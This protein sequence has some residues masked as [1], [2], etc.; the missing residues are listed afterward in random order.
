MHIKRFKK[1]FTKPADRV[2][3]WIFERRKKCLFIL[4]LPLTLAFHL[5]GLWIVFHHLDWIGVATFKDGMWRWGTLLTISLF[6]WFAVAYSDPIPITHNVWNAP[7]D[8]F[9]NVEDRVTVV[10]AM[11]FLLLIHVLFF[12]G[13]SWVVWCAHN[14][15]AI[16]LQ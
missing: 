4:I 16:C 8:K 9:S 7:S 14:G 12:I 6:F 1:A 11:N 10:M 13:L 5:G 2:I 3:D 15:H